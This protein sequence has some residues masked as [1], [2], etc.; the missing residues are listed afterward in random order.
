M[1]G[2][3]AEGAP[4]V[5]TGPKYVDSS[6]AAASSG[7]S[8]LFGALSGRSDAVLHRT[9]VWLLDWRRDKSSYLAPTT[10]LGDAIRRTL[11]G[12]W[13]PA[14]FDMSSITAVI[15]LF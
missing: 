8:L 14:I 12:E 10:P 5:V 7:I 3:Y 1:E 2:V 4:I 15:T 11:S 9:P 6:R 13:R